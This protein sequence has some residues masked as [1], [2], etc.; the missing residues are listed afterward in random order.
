MS[1]A[2]N[3]THSVSRLSTNTAR[4]N[5]AQSI[6]AVMSRGQHTLPELPYGYDVGRACHSPFSSL[7]I[8]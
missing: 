4:R 2:R 6:P 8:R 7:Y 5:I 1:F 3:I